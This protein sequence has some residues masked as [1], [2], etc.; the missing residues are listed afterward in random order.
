MSEQREEEK[1][2]K[3]TFAY[4]FGNNENKVIIALNMKTK[5]AQV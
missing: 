3:T 1:D 2:L 4:V 5:E